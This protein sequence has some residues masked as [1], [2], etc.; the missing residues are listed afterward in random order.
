MQTQLLKSFRV[1]VHCGPLILVN[2]EHPVSPRQSEDL[3]EVDERYRDIKIKR[4]AARMLREVLKQTDQSIKIHPVSGYREKQEQQKIWDDSLRENGRIFTQQYVALPGCSEHETG[5]AIDLCYSTDIQEVDFIR[6]FFPSDGVC[7]EFR[8]L[9]LRYGF[10][11]RYQKDKE[12][13]TTIAHEPW[14]FRYVGFPHS[15]IMQSCDLCLEEYV[16]FIRNYS[17]LKP[18]VYY[19]GAYCINIFFLPDIEREKLASMQG[20][21]LVSG[22]NVDGYIVTVWSNING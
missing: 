10:I 19:Y 5:F 15:A 21:F 8:K 2:S 20:Q 11:E 4:N 13:I 16:D 6:P 18:L 7:R 22:N 9:A 14:H 12:H 3:D 1:D 17:K